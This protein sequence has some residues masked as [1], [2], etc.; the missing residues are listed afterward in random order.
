MGVGASFMCATVGDGAAL[1]I[2]GLVAGSAHR[3]S[4]SPAAGRLASPRRALGSKKK[5]AS[6]AA[7]F[8]ITGFVC[9]NG[10]H[11]VRQARTIRERL[12]LAPLCRS[13]GVDKHPVSRDKP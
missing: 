3:V 1:A 13:G 2:D 5:R 10:P 12:H 8:C 7:E 6:L 4:A 9:K 11:R